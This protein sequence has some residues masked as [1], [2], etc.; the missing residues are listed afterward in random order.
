MGSDEAWR[1][2]GDSWL[3]ED[4]LGEGFSL[5]DEVARR[6]GIT[7]RRLRAG[8]R[9]CAMLVPI[10]A[11]AAVRRGEPG[12]SVEGLLMN[13]VAAGAQALFFSTSVEADAVEE[14]V[15]TDA[16]SKLQLQWPA[17]VGIQ[18][19]E[20]G[21]KVRQTL[22]KLGVE[23]AASIAKL[24]ISPERGSTVSFELYRLPDE[25]TRDLAEGPPK[26]GEGR[27]NLRRREEWF[28]RRREGGCNPGRHSK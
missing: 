28:K 15:S 25:T 23:F 10:Q 7:V 14:L 8:A 1:I 18:A 22:G 27:K 13:G 6:R 9:G 12:L 24:T 3:L 26:I 17:L 5:L 21:E 2:A 11:L 16:M 20:A 19:S 4:S